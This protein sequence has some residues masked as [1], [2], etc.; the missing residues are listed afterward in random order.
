MDLTDQIT[1]ETLFNKNQT[2][3]RLKAEASIPEVEAHCEEH[4]IPYGFAVDLIAQM[5]LRKRA[6]VGVLV[7][8]LRHHFK[9]NVGD[10]PNASQA[11][12]DM[13]LKAAQTDLVDLG[14]NLRGDLEFI[15]ALD[16]EPE[17]KAEMEL[18]QYP[19]PMVI[20]PKPVNQNTDT[21]M[22]T[23][24]GSIILKNN[25]HEDDVCL[26]HI[27]RVNQTAYRINADTVRLVRN[28]WAGLDHQKADET[29]AEY[30][31]RVKAFQKYD[32]V[33]R[34]VIDNLVMNED[35]FYLT[36]K[37]DKRGRTYAQGYHTNPQGNGWNKAVIEFAEAEL[38]NES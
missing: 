7:G 25:H 24:K 23:I 17:T 4:Q 34:D 9:D 35:P 20:P 37:Y 15:I 8:I 1:L 21:G 13:L 3:R 36:N 26:D 30:K 16:I 11:C 32:R 6:P 14:E 27:N 38:L 10:S 5:C 28:S 22:F 2:M 18:Y 12:A 29:E 19:L 33:S 31:T